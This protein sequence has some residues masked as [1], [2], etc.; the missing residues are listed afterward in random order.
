MTRIA[1]INILADISINMTHIADINIVADISINMTHIA[2]ID[3]MIHID[4]SLFMKKLF[5]LQLFIS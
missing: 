2:D 3:I 4:W 1:D 5:R